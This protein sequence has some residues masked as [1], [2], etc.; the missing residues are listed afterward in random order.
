MSPQIL[1]LSK[2]EILDLSKNRIT[3]IPEGIRKLSSL[4]FLAV[5]R[6]KITRLPLALG[7]MPSLSKL[8]FDENPIVFPPLEEILRPT[9]SRGQASAETGEEKDVCQKVKRYLKQQS[10]RER[11][12]GKATNG[13]EDTKYTLHNLVIQYVA[14]ANHHIVKA[15]SRR[16]VH[17]GVCKRAGDFRSVPASVEQRAFWTSRSAHR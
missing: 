16:H 12:V 1:Q 5:A 7:D 8:K 9:S 6:N 2:L 11:L 13:D 15:M 4:K 3:S 10:M 14:F 17:L